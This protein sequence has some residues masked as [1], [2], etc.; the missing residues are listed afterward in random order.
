MKQPTIV[1]YLKP[2]CPWT[3]GVISVLKKH[4]LE[5]EYRDI[6]ANPAHFQEMVQKSG[7]TGSPCVEIDGQ[8]LADVGGGEVEAWMRQH[9]FLASPDSRP[10]EG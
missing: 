10:E 1:A 6:L 3:S 8:M 4:G 2:Y 7:Q 5:F 9:R